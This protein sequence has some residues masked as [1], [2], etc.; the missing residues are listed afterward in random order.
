[1]VTAFYNIYL[2]P[3]SRF[4]GPK[5]AAATPIPFVLHIIRGDVFD[6][7]NSLHT[8]YG[9]IVRI[10]PDELSFAKPSAWHDIYASRPQ[11]PRPTLGGIDL[12]NKVKSIATATSIEDHDRMRKI[13]NHAFSDRA[14]REQEYILQNYTNLL[15]TRLLDRITMAN[16]G[17]AQVEIGDWY[18]FTTFDIIGDL[19][20]G[21][22]FHSLENS[23]HHPWVNSIFMGL[24]A[25]TILTIFDYFGPVRSLMKWI[26]PIVTAHEAR[27]HFDW[28]RKRIDQRI[29]AKT[30]RPDFMT[31]ILQNNN[32]K[33]IT[34][35]EIDSTVALLILAGSDTSATTSCSSTWF[36]LKNPAAMA[37]L[38]K[39][40]RTT[41]QTVEE[42]TIA[43]VS[44][45]PYLHAVL[46]EAMRLHPL[47]PVN[48]PRQ[49]D[50]Q[51]TIIC[52]HEIPVGVSRHTSIDMRDR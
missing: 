49:V 24:K 32:E 22:S 46:Q 4:Q 10:N 29:Q 15:I 2:H 18:N 33:G 27:T 41:F 7:T 52:G 19:C 6:W 36:L 25:G 14:L 31:H 47:G 37:R 48:V 30:D 12:P 28:S 21:E 39:E 1:M 23:E 43:S 11:L 13:L 26:L 17:F 9:E 16:E 40:I 8:Q 34:R 38:Q 45:L 42:I 44:K 50:R 35:D 51:G 5:L 3:L 20:F